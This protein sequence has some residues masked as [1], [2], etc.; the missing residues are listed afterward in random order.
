MMVV[1]PPRPAA[2]FFYA[3]GL[4]GVV[5]PLPPAL[6]GPDWPS[7]PSALTFRCSSSEVG[8]PTQ[9]KT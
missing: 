1:L 5:L 6:P 2:A 8:T 7:L 4:E 9:F 3:A